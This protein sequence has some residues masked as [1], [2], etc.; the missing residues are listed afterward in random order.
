MSENKSTS[1]IVHA[2]TETFPA[3]VLAAPV[4]VIVKFGA[5]WCP[6]CRLMEPYLE[7]I[8]RQISDRAIIV[9][10]NRDQ[11][12]DLAQAYGVTSIPHLL[13]FKNGEHVQVEDSEEKYGGLGLPDYETLRAFV[14]E[15]LF[16]SA[17]TPSEADRE[18]AQIAASEDEAKNKRLESSPE[19]QAFAALI[20]PARQAYVEATDSAQGAFDADEIDEDELQE[21]KQK[22]QSEFRA[23]YGSEA[24]KPVT[25]AYK[26][27]YDELEQAYKATL[28]AAVER[29]FPFSA[30]TEQAKPNANQPAVGKV[31]AIGDP[32]CQA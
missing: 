1:A 20:E 28:V 11:C 7:A 29:L 15:Q 16:G 9:E 23:F 22:A 25:E 8:A 31:C 17:G 3:Q 19:H 32:T 18:L 2:T 10:V 13:L 26:K 6:P 4:P 30:P 12:P 27:V 24:V 21:R 14:H 5:D